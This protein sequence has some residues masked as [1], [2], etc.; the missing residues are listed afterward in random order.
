[1]PFSRFKISLADFSLLETIPI[2]LLLL[3]MEYHRMYAAARV[4]LWEVMLL[5]RYSLPTTLD[6]SYILSY[7]SCSI[8]FLNFS[9]PMEVDNKSSVVKFTAY[10]NPLFVLIK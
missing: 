5:V 8:I 9:Y 2:V 3:N 7:S 4:V 6:K 10:L 1:M